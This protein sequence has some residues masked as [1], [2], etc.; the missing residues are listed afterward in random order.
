MAYANFKPT[1]WSKH[2]QFELPKFT[3]LENDCDYKFSGEAGKGKKVKILGVAR[4]TIGNYTGADIGAPETVPDSAVYLDIDQA[5]YFNFM[6]D[7]VDEAQATEGL[8]TALMSESTR[9]MAE[10]RDTYIAKL[11]AL[12]A[13]TTSATTA[14]TSKATAKAALDA[15]LKALWEN[16][17]SQ[18]DDVTM[19]LSPLVY[20]WM[21]EYISEAKTQNDA[22]IAAGVLGMY[23]GA[24]I[25][26]TNNL[27]SDG[28]DKHVI[29]KTSKAVAFCGGINNVEAYRP[30]GLF[31]DAV[32][33]LNT[34]G[35]KVVRPKELY[36]LKAH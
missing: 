31:S 23:G 6:V 2:F 33:G 18:K 16:G 21:L 35:G 15:G 19:Y 27:Y 22:L 8:M 1:I 25:K 17:V 34:F 30:E 20:Q 28:V 14:V 3:V 10:Q 4:P 11:C 12:N 29:I 24:K 13:G 26:M 5:K 32:K 36:V 7:D 9:A